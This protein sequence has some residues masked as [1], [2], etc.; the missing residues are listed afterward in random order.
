[1]EAAKDSEGLARWRALSRMPASDEMEQTFSP[2]SILL[3]YGLQ[4]LR[5]ESELSFLCVPILSPRK[6]G[7]KFEN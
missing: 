1:M 4:S 3:H 5:K 6:L 2:P 7:H